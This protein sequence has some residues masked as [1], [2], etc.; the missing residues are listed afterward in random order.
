MCDHNPPKTWLCYSK[1]GAEGAQNSC[2]GFT[3]Y[4]YFPNTAFITGFM[5]DM[6]D[7]NKEVGHRRWILNSEAE[8]FSYGATKT[9]EALYCVFNKINDTISTNYVSYPWNGYVPYDLIFSKWSFSIP[10]KYKVDYSKAK[11]TITNNQGQFVP[12]KLFKVDDDWLPD[13]TLVW[14]MTSMFTEKDENSGINNLVKY[15]F[16][17]KEINV[18]IDNV[19]VDGVKKSYRYIVKIIKL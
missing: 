12:F 6:G 1:V 5:E 2:L 15:G 4:K 14:K 18:F 16:I 13:N 10:E 19:F 8:V 17:G 9:T 11:L 7:E 3:D